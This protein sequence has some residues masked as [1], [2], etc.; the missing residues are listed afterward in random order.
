MLVL[1]GQIE[2]RLEGQVSDRFDS[3]KESERVWLDRQ[4]RSATRRRWLLI[5]A[6]VLVAI[7][8]AWLTVD[9][10]SGDRAATAT[11]LVDQRAVADGQQALS[12]WGRFAATNDLGTVKE[13][14][15]TDGP[16]YK[17]L[18]K[19]AKSRKPL[20]PPPYTVTVS[21]LQV[22][23]PRQDQRV[24]RGRVVFR[25]PGEQVQ[26]YS[27]DIWMR[28]DH[29]AGGRW[30]LWTVRQTPTRAEELPDQNGALR[31]NSSEALSQADQGSASSMRRC[32]LWI[33]VPACHVPG[34]MMHDST[35]S[36]VSHD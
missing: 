10:P 35:S 13:S 23:A 34:A 27:W 7:F 12:D 17:L 8:L 6:L 29:A 19:E 26:T 16:Q 9:G 5:G 31:R 18:A 32:G 11:T 4:R 1:V 15:W 33:H 20:G 14:F 22:L 28:R 2:F 25:R 36:K 3:T 21:G 30:R 24:L